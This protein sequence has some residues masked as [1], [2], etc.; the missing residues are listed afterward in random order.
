MGIAG[1]EWNR[2]Q[3]GNNQ[4]NNRRFSSELREDLHCQLKG[5]NKF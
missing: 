4:A 1:G 3:R 5:L 2:C